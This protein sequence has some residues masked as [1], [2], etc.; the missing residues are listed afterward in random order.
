MEGQ[1]TS[2]GEGALASPQTCLLPKPAQGDSRNHV[3][4]LSFSLAVFD[5]VAACD[6]TLGD[7]EIYIWIAPDHTALLKPLNLQSL[8][9]NASRFLLHHCMSN[10]ICNWYAVSRADCATHATGSH[11]FGSVVC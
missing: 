11:I 10:C 6:L 7:D 2:G 5:P 9:C 8:H 4:R 1:D 3:Q